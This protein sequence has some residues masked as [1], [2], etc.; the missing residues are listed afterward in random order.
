MP[1][2]LID[3]EDLRQLKSM[4][5]LNDAVINQEITTE[6]LLVPGDTS[7]L[8]DVIWADDTRV[9]P[10]NADVTFSG[11][12]YEIR[13]ADSDSQNQ[14]A[15][16][17][18]SARIGKYRPGEPF[19]QGIYVEKD[20]TPVGHMDVGYFRNNEA[21]GPRLRF[22]SDGSWELRIGNG[23]VDTVIPQS[24]W[25]GGTPRE[26]TNENEQVSGEF[27][28]LDKMDG[29]GPSGIDLTDGVDHVILFIGAWY[30]GG[31]V[32]PCVYGID[33]EGNYVPHPIGVFEPKTDVTFQ[34]PNQPATVKLDNEGSTTEDTCYV[35]GRQ[36]STAGRSSDETRKASHLA[37]DDT[38]ITVTSTAD[39]Y[40]PILAFRRKSGKEGVG[41]GAGDLQI[42]TDQRLQVYVEINADI[43]E[44]NTTFGEISTVENPEESAIEVADPDKTSL[45]VNNRGTGFSFNGKLYGQGKNDNEVSEKDPFEFPVAREDVVV[46]WARSVTG[47]DASIE[48]N[49]VLQEA[50]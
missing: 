36:Y 35:A 42:F 31:P 37:G 49:L 13:T 22:K 20:S 3:N 14:N 2:P 5:G 11:G 18:E 8:R 28:G 27:F 12:K 21:N 33:D 41:V 4:V 40:T 10:D 38:T 16:S 23:G 19:Y 50:R 48:A 29:T 6:F 9:R 39:T 26:V 1:N 34:Q 43:D 25:E 17:F 32:V 44:A 47:N 15:I 30:G 45:A 7:Q 46:I 24:S